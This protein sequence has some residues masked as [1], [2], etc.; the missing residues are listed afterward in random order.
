MLSSAFRTQTCATN[1]EM[2]RAG[3]VVIMRYRQQMYDAQSESRR[4]QVS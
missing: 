1:N 4:L 2:F 3:T